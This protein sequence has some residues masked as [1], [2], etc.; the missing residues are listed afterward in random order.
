MNR[1]CC[2]TSGAQRRSC[3]SWR[4]AARPRPAI[5]APSV[6]VGRAHRR[7]CPPVDADDGGTSPMLWRVSRVLY[8]CRYLLPTVVVIVVYY[9]VACVY[10]HL[11]PL[12]I[13]HLCGVWT[14][15][16]HYCQWQQ[17]QHHHSR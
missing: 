13:R 17:H 2:A 14:Y 12:P 1:R 5:A 15:Y 11:T 4:S 16:R 6:A 9:V 8:T 7:C 3:D 10:H